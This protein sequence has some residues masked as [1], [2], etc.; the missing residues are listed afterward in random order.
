MKN[1]AV[2][3]VRKKRISVKSKRKISLDKITVL[4]LYANAINA[5]PIANNASHFIGSIK[6]D[7]TSD[8]TPMTPS[9]NLNC[10]TDV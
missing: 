4:F 6:R 3:Q 7:N 5:M 1:I 10:P 9:H 2:T 8:A